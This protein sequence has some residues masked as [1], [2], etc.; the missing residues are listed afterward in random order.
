MRAL[1]GTDRGLG[2]LLATQPDG[3]ATADSIVTTIDQASD[4][5]AQVTLPLNKAVADPAQRKQVEALAE[6]LV[7]LRDLLA[8]P[9]AAKLNLPIG[10]NA[11]DGD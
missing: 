6:Q 3:K 9:V 7:L 1:F 11:L 10:F 2:G 5:L 8:G 4:A